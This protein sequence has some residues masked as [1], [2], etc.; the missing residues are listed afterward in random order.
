MLIDD[1]F[2]RLTHEI[3]GAAI[4]VH[5]AIGPGL[6]ESI[7]LACLQ[8]ELATRKIRF[9]THRAVPIRYKGF[10]LDATHR[11]DLIVEGVVVVELKSVEHVLAVHEAQ[12]TTYLR[13]TNL[14]LGLLI[15]FN[16]AKLTDGVKRRL[17]SRYVGP[18]GEGV[19]TEG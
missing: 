2:N 18:D 13:M 19:T 5:A 10:T 7:Y 15:N 14:P 12:L 3:I 9:E 1:A 4:E 6:V 16:V 11:V 8:F 17:N